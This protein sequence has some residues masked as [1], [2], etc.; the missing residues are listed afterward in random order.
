M[1]FASQPF[2]TPSQAAASPTGAFLLRPMIQEIVNL[3]ATTIPEHVAADAP[4]IL[5]DVDRSHT[6]DADTASVRRV[7]GTLIRDAVAAAAG[8]LA[9]SDAPALREVVITSIQT[10]DAIEIE[11]ADSSATSVDTIGMATAAAESMIS[12]LGGTLRVYRCPEGGKA[13]TM[14]LPRRQV[15]TAA[16]RRAA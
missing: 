15:A 2:G 11:I 16:I 12:R 9:A 13:V 3:T 10:A 7:L 14:S 1:S 4:L 5:I 6:V 8:P